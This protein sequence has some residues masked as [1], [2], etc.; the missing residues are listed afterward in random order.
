MVIYRLDG[1]FSAV[2]CVL[3]R[4]IV[5]PESN[6]PRIHSAFPNEHTCSKATNTEPIRAS[7]TLLARSDSHRPSGSERKVPHFD[8]SW[9]L[10]MSGRYA[11]W[12]A[13]SLVD[14]AINVTAFSVRT[15]RSFNS[16]SREVD[17]IHS[18]NPRPFHIIVVPFR[19]FSP[20][21]CALCALLRSQSA[22]S[23]YLW[24]LSLPTLLAG[25]QFHLFHGIFHSF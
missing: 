12:I 14:S 7:S 19:P 22:Y 25:I 11:W 1:A 21:S 24:Q 23:H 5:P 6:G 18:S 20:H 15:V 13:S 10:R 16:I 3:L 8:W 9:A 2:A 17:A 4:F